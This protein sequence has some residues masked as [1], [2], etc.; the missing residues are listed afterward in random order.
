MYG[1]REK[2]VKQV[3]NCLD[4][5]DR[6]IYDRVELDLE[7]TLESIDRLLDNKETEKAKDLCTWLRGYLRGLV[8]AQY[9]TFE[10]ES[11]FEELVRRANYPISR[12]EKNDWHALVK[13]ILLMP[14]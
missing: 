8:A 3:E 7:K 1:I 12:T 13:E 6:Q 14:R 9:L 10:K 11:Y 5:I 2:L 4:D